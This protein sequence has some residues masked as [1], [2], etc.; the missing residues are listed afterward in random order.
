MKAKIVVVDDHPAVIEGVKSIFSKSQAGEI[1]GWATSGKEAQMVIESLGPDIVI[2]DLR[3]PDMNGVELARWIREIDPRIKIIVFTMHSFK[4][5]MGPLLK[6][7]VAG[8]VQKQDPTRDLELAVRVVCNGGVYY[9]REI[10]TFLH[11]T[12]K[13]C[14]GDNE[15]FAMLTPRELEVFKLVSNGISIKETARNLGISVNTV[16]T[17]KQHIC[18]KLQVRSASAWTRE[19]VKQGI[20]ALNRSFRLPVHAYFY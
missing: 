13:L 16:Q 8:Y 4:E 7:G 6:I 2:L 17:H 3:I 12:R 20:V 11:G 18:E 9:C 14:A 19:A 1:V 5:F 15:P 10:Q